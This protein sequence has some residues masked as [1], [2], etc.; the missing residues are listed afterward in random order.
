[1]ALQ[2]GEVLADALRH[3]Q[4]LID[5]KVCRFGPP[6]GEVDEGTVGGPLVWPIT[7]AQILDLCRE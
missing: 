4:I 7:P 5:I 6:L 2:I 3:L 1:M